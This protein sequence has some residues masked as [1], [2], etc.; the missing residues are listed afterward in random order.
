MPSIQTKQPSTVLVAIDIAKLRHEVL[1]EGPN[2]KSRKRLILL[3]T[4]VE[5]RHFADYLH[6]LKYAVRVGF[7]ATGN[8]HRPLAHFLMTE[9]FQLEVSSVAGCSPHPRGHA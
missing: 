9:G 2:W 7:E 3:N 1:I 8:Y 5:F 4:A 6:S